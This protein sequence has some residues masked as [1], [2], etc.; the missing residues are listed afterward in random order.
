MKPSCLLSIVENPMH[1]SLMHLYPPIPP[2]VVFGQLV[3]SQFTVDRYRLLVDDSGKS[4]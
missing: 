2:I 4:E 1:V 3:K